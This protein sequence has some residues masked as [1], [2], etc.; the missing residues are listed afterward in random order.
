[1]DWVIIGGGFK[2]IITAV[3]LLEYN[4]NVTLIESGKSLGGHLKGIKWQGYNLDLGCQLFDNSD[5]EI[6]AYLLKILGNNVHPV[7]VTYGGITDKNW[8]PNYTVPDLTHESSLE[9]IMLSELE[10]LNK[11]EDQEIKSLKEYLTARFGGT[12]GQKLCDAAEK[13]LHYNPALLGAEASKV[14]FFERVKMFNDIVS[15]RLKKNIFYDE[16]LA[17]YSA[18]EPM[19]YYS[20]AKSKFSYRNFYPREGGMSSFCE[21]ATSYLLDNGAKLILSDNVDSVSNNTLITENGLELKFDKLVWSADINYL[22]K[23]LLKT[24]RL[25]KY[26]YALPMV[27][28]YFEIS[29]RDIGPYTYVHDHSTG[30]YIFRASTGG[31]Y[32]QQTDNGKTYICCEIP[33]SLES[34]LWDDPGKY[35]TEIWKEA[36]MLKICKGSLPESF[37]ILKAPK[38]FNL[39]LIGFDSE[40]SKVKYEL[41]NKMPNLFFIDPLETSLMNI[42]TTILKEIKI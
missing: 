13:K 31:V 34:N 36:C 6:T 35:V 29:I 4:Q 25:N 11:I 7:N 18:K 28:V 8:S 39:P 30:S 3:I 19:K 10:A 5:S 22:E 16:R 21:L 24:E 37:Y 41:N 17:V 32:S 33:T 15:N 27:L 26:L 2:G 23:L 12:A 40:Y 20:K 14:L 9:K 38:T 1:M 42:T